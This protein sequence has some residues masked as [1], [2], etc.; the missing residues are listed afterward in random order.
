MRKIMIIHPEGNINNNPNLTGIVEILCEQG[1]GVDIYSPRNP[2]IPQESPCDGA[3]LILSDLENKLDFSALLPL[4][5]LED[6]NK[7]ITFIAHNIPLYDLIIGVDRGIIEAGIIASQKKVPYAL[8]SYEIL[9]TEETGVEYK[10]FDVQFSRNVSFAICQDRVRSY[11]LSREYD[12]PIDRIV[13]VPVAGRK[14]KGSEKKYILHDALG[15]EREKKIALYMGSVTYKWS[16]VDDLIDTVDNW[17]DDWVLV[18]HHR[19]GQQDRSLAARIQNLKKK[20]VFFSPFNTLPFDN[21]T[22]LYRVP[23]WA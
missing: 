14:A 22:R 9:F 20:N 23:T 1:F 11:H 10:T 4:P 19:Y 3:R 5:A 6:S 8:L 17:D 12:I 2:S 7:L 16:G 13:D 21:F 15:L 18:L